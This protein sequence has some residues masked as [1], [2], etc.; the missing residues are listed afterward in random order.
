[1]SDNSDDLVA[2]H[3]ANVRKQELTMP[4][5]FPGEDDEVYYRRLEA[6]IKDDAAT[7]KTDLRGWTGSLPFHL[8]K[9]P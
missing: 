8:D 7:S 9:S 3:Q 5:Q 6:W 2:R 1:M 4:K